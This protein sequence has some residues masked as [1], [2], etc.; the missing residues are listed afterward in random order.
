MEKLTYTG[1][2][3]VKALSAWA[4]EQSKGKKYVLV[5]VVFSDVVARRASKLPSSAHSANDWPNGYWHDGCHKKW[6][7]GRKI[8]AQNACQTRD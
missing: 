6:S 2:Q 5:A 8:R 1:P 7:E 4:A 3:N